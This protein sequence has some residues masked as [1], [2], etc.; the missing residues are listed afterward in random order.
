M[1]RGQTNTVH[2]K[3]LQA[4]AEKHFLLLAAYILGESGREETTNN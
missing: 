2:T 1:E 3:A 4:G